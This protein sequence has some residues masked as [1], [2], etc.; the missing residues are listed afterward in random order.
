M[1]VRSLG[2]T[3]GATILFVVVPLLVID[4]GLMYVALTDL[5]RRERVRLFTKQGWITLIIF[6]AIIGSAFYL[7]YGREE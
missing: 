3:E 2:V 7:L 4:F 6:L 5:M 1:P